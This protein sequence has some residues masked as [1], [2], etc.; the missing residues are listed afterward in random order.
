MFSIIIDFTKIVKHSGL[1]LLESK[2]KP[3]PSFNH[4]IGLILTIPSSVHEKLLKQ[5]VGKPR[6]D[7]INSPLFVNSIIDFLY[8]QY[9]PHT[10]VCELQFTI[11]DTISSVLDSLLYYIPNDFKILTYT[12]PQNKKI[13]NKLI[14][15]SFRNPYISNKSQLGQQFNSEMLLMSKIN[16]IDEPYDATNDIEFTLSRHKQIYTAYQFKFDSFTIKK[17]KK[18]SRF[19]SS[20]NNDGTISQKEIVGCFKLKKIEKI[21]DSDFIHIIQICDNSFTFG[22]EEEVNNIKCKFSFHTHPFT[23]YDIYKFK[24]AWPS[25]ADYIGFLLSV[26]TGTLFHIVIGNEGIYIISLSREWSRNTDFT[27]SD[28][29]KNFIIENFKFRKNKANITLKSY[30]NKVNHIQFQNK[31]IFN[32]EFRNWNELKNPFSVWSLNIN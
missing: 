29:L 32:L 17:L 24:L 21:N 15:N 16:N 31:K 1:T 10:K 2:I 20:I 22:T 18:L 9:E 11:P 5:P 27:V 14:I 12:Q 30:I 4:T 8:M 6:I 23:L 7:F 26:E 25:N 3:F 28:E 19:G 13:I